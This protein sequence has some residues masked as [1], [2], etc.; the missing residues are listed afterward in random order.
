MRLRRSKDCAMRRLI[1]LLVLLNLFALPAYAQ[2]QPLDPADAAAAAQAAA[3]RAEESADYVNRVAGEAANMLGIFEAV[4]TSI[5]ILTGVVVPLIAV[6]GGLAGL[7][8]LR[9]A[10]AELSVARDQMLAEVESIRT[11]MN[12]DLSEKQAEL[13]TLR[14]V[15]E[16]SA[17]DE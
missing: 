9:D 5:G 8:S 15:L 2:E 4:G 12:D 17:L 3:E 13:D 7:R 11:K 14:K 6:I 10:R 16:A 1:F